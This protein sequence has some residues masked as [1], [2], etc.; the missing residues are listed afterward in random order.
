[1]TKRAELAAAELYRLG[2]SGCCDYPKFCDCG[3]DL[4]GLM[5]RSLKTDVRYCPQCGKQVQLLYNQE[6]LADLEAAI[7]AALKEPVVISAIKS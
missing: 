3:Y 1:M 6:V 7:D 5:I 2:W 4:L